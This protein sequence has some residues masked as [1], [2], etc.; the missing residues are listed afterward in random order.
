VADA[1][2]PAVPG[3][4]TGSASNLADLVRSAAARAGS[5]TA[6]RAGAERV[7][8]AELD[9]RVDACAGGLQRLGAVPGDRVAMLLGNGLPFVVGWFGVLRAGLVAVPVNPGYTAPE[10]SHQLTDSGAS[11][12]LV[13]AHLASPL[14]GALASVPHVVVVGTQPWQ[15]LTTL[16]ERPSASPRGGEDLAALVYTSGT[17]GRPRGAMLT[18]R[19][20]LANLDQGAALSTPVMTKDD[21]VLLVLPMFHIY[22]LNPGLG[23]VAA[24]AATGVLVD[25]FD[26]VDCLAVIQSGKIT[27]VVGAPPMYVAWSMLPD[28]ARSF[29]SVRLAV[30]GAAPLPP[31]VLRRMSELTGQPVFEGYGLTETGPVLT[32]TL[33]AGEAKPGSIGRPLPGVELHLVDEQGERVDEDDPG[34]IVVRGQNL[35]SGYW[36]A[37]SDG[38]DADGWFATGDVAYAD[39]DGDLHLVDRRREL[40]L[41]SGFN[42]YPREV[43]TVL[44]EHP[45]VA[46]VA[47]I[48]IP[49]PYT[50]QSVKAL[51][52]PVPGTSPT[53][54]ELTAF[55]ARSLARFKCPTLV[56]LVETL[57]H[58][59]T[60]KVSKGQLRGV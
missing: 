38:P 40:I 32:T 41:V 45:D 43:E 58:S 46:E 3:A 24:H 60:G 8:W 59:A 54:A 4:I 1:R 35:F 29:R 50:G 52:V 23:Q 21:V 53:P 20:L 49:H 22:G 14:A 39:A 16:G 28:L 48:G 30:S 5:H 36:P 7:T 17:S 9:E 2:R 56:E 11:V 13:E 10:V 47:V 27:N 44:G 34:E 12:A 51:I 19:A 18:H 6:I 25:R 55:A 15:E 33:V 31:D 26:P 37:G 57:P 42:V